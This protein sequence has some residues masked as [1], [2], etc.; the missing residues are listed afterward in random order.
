MSDRNGHRAQYGKGSVVMDA[1]EARE[2]T[3]R[4][5]ASLMEVATALR[6]IRDG[7]LYR[8][9]HATFDDYGRENFGA[10]PTGFIDL[11]LAAVDGQVVSPEVLHAF[12][13]AMAA[14]RAE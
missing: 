5:R 12:A 13:V 8:E 11:A 1:W 6:A 10:L 14:E 7:G 2:L 3:E 9:S 4:A